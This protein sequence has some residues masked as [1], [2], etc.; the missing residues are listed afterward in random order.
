[1]EP[2][3][4]VWAIHYKTSCVILVTAK[5]PINTTACKMVRGQVLKHWNLLLANHLIIKLIK[6]PKQLFNFLSHNHTQVEIV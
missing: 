6:V 1:M 5:G 3:K 4:L 2:S